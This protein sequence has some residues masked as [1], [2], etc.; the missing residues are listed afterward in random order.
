MGFGGRGNVRVM[1]NAC[2]AVQEAA[3]IRLQARFVLTYP[4]LAA[5]SG[6]LGGS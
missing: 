5:T 1:G 2:M 3:E 6:A 4:L